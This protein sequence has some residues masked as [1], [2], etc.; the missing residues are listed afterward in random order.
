MIK[1]NVGGIA[2][3]H[4]ARRRRRDVPGFLPCLGLAHAG[5]NTAAILGDELSCANG[6]DVELCAH[7][8]VNT[9]DLERR[10]ADWRFDWTGERDALL[11]WQFA[12]AVKSSGFQFA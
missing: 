5:H 11:S 6:S 2:L 9:P 8:G 12:N 1:K 10:Y 4:I 3:Q 7:P